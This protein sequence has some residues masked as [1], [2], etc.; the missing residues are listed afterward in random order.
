MIN[1][2]RL[3]ERPAVF[4][5]AGAIIPLAGEKQTD[6]RNP[7]EMII[8]IFAGANG[9]FA[10]Y[11]DDGE[12]Y[13]YQQEKYCITKLDFKWMYDILIPLFLHLFP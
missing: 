1:V 3:L 5:K 7:E 11:E 2:F 10:L 4:A 9:Q 8:I 12:S 13:C 6:L